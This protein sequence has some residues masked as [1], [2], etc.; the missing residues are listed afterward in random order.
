MPSE[1]EISL[2]QNYTVTGLE[3]CA[4]YSVVLWITNSGGRAGPQTARTPVSVGGPGELNT[5]NIM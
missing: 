2:V 4:D 3:P 5:R 1:D